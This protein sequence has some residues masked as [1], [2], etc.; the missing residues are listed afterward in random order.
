ML[1][2]LKADRIILITI[3]NDMEKKSREEKELKKP[4]RTSAR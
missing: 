4:K 3:L 1:E 2:Q